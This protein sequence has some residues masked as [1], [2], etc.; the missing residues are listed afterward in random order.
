MAGTVRRIIER[1]KE[2]RSGGNSVV[3]LTVETRLVLQGFDP[4]RFDYETPD[5]PGR[6]A[7]MRDVAAEMHVDVDDLIAQADVEPDPDA[8]PAPAPGAPVRSGDD[9]VAAAAQATAAAAGVAP[10][11]RAHAPVVPADHPLRRVRELADEA[12]GTIGE[13][14][15]PGERTGAPFATLVKASLLMGLYSIASDRVLCD[16]LH[17]N[18]LFRW[19]LDLGAGDGDYDP[20]AFAA[21][22]EQ[23]L[24]DAH[25]GTFFDR[26]VAQA[27]RERLFSSG[28]FQANGRQ[29]RGWMSQRAGT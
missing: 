5:D 18:E 9:G 22:R 11:A 25:A 6:L 8:T 1:I 17:Y 21:D 12:L 10:G 3:A 14:A 4:Q 23:A 2:Q 29:I 13:A 28:L 15:T 16:Q 19:F 27:G 7:R 20:E 26:V 24:A